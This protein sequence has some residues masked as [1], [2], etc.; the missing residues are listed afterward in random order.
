LRC[1]HNIPPLFRREIDGY[2]VPLKCTS[3][4][5]HVLYKNKKTTGP[6]C[7]GFLKN[8]PDT[9]WVPS[10]YPPGVTGRKIK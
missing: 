3:D 9:L 2:K 5:L 6:F 1:R 4:F 7:D 8:S 10:R